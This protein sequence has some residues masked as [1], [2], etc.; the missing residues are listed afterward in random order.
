MINDWKPIVLYQ[1]GGLNADKQIRHDVLTSPYI[2]KELHEWQQNYEELIP[3]I[4]NYTVKG[5]LILDP[6]LGSGTTAYCA[7]M[8]NRLCIGVE[9]EE[10]YCEIAAKRCCQTVMRL[11]I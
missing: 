3:L 5:D 6:F 4:N 9:L 2:Q 1:K 7:K 11:G 10:R 8:L